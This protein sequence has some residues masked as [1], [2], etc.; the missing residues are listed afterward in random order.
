MTPLPAQAGPQVGGRSWDLSAVIDRPEGA[1]GV[2]YATGNENSGMSLF[3]EGDRL[4]FDYNCFGDHHVVES[5]VAVPTGASV[6]GVRFRRED[7]AGEATLVIDGADCGTVGLPFVMRMIS[8]V[9]ASIGFDHGSPVSR[10]YTDEYP[11]QGTLRQVDVQL[12]TPG[13]AAAER[14]ATEERAGLSRQ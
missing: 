14:A 11:F 1:G 7:Q 2:L 9:G 6:V 13:E 5:E 12:L 4:V 8:S 10:R 3:V